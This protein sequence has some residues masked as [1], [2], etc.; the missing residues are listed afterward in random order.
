MTKWS[1]PNPVAYLIEISNDIAFLKI[2]MQEYCNKIKE[3]QTESDGISRKLFS[4]K[5][6]K[7]LAIWA[8]RLELIQQEEKAYRASFQ[9]ARCLW[10]LEGILIKTYISLTKWRRSKD[11]KEK[12]EKRNNSN[13]LLKDDDDD[14]REKE[15]QRQKDED[16]S[17][18]EYERCGNDQAST[19]KEI[20]K[21]LS[22]SCDFMI[23]YVN[24]QY[25]AC[26][27]CNYYFNKKDLGI[28][29]MIRHPRDSSR[30][31]S[32]TTMIASSTSRG[33]EL[34]HCLEC[35]KKV[36]TSQTTQLQSQQ[37]Q[38]GNKNGQGRSDSDSFSINNTQETQQNTNRNTHVLKRKKKRKKKKNASSLV[39]VPPEK[40]VLYCSSPTSVVEGCVLIE[41]DDGDSD[42]EADEEKDNVAKIDNDDNGSKCPSDTTTTNNNKEKDND[43]VDK[44]DDSNEIWVDYLIKTGSI[45]SLN[46][47]M[48]EVLGTED[49]IL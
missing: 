10:Q 42:S 32:S 5:P 1:S 6:S 25:C 37:H 48:D 16:N 19:S 47:Y 20:V 41:K 30:W 39:V 44:D 8:R 28:F 45:I 4:R 31:I 13:L 22:Q 12:I 15:I 7:T 18:K 38:Q 14:D 34:F 2:K 27:V 49:S 17:A 3:Q 43:V 40:E 35:Y 36:P 26:S 24:K 23:E 21:Y 46:H 33:Y 11:E 29:G 9:L